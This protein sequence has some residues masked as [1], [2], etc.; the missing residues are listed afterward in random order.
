[1]VFLCFS[2]SLDSTPV[3][4]WVFFLLPSASFVKVSSNHKQA[5]LISKEELRI[6][7][8]T[9][10]RLPHC[11]NKTF[12][13]YDTNKQAIYSCNVTSQRVRVAILAVEKQ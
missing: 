12:M 4:F 11:I 5:L 10:F 9:I 2:Y 6:M 8:S 1:L 3:L 13:F 7:E